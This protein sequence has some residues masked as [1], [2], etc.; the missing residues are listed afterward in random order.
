MG[1]VFLQEDESGGRD[2][3]GLQVDTASRVQGMASGD[4]ILMTRSVSDNARAVLRSEDIPEVCNL[5]WQDYGAYKIKGVDHPI[6]IC[7]IGEREKAFL[8]TP[9]DREKAK[10]IS[11]EDEDLVKGWRPYAGV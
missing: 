3:L 8:S 7:E 11:T 6:G 10:S 1:E 2:I 9:A 4:Q 5:S